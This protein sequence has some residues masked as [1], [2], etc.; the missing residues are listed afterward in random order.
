MLLKIYLGIS[1]ISLLPKAIIMTLND[2]NLKKDG[3]VLK[4][5]KDNN[6]NI[7]TDG[8][9]V[10]LSSLIPVI[11]ILSAFKSWV[12]LFRYK[13]QYLK[14]KNELLLYDRVRY[15]DRELTEKDVYNEFQKT[16]EALL[17]DLDI[18]RLSNQEEVKTLVQI[19]NLI[20]FLQEND[21]EIPEDLTALPDDEIL[22]VL[23]E[24]ASRVKGKDEMIE[25]EDIDI[26]E[27]TEEVEESKNEIKLT[28]KK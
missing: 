2:I 21:V 3:L 6:N 11:N 26:K 14:Y 20:F 16:Q 28:Y 27:S 18:S 17:S 5:N 9:A 13:Y 15:E 7:V 10:V 8:I 12:D 24:M 23:Q 1:V 4:N 22:E 25:E 19:N